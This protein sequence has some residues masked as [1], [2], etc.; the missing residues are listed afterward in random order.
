VPRDRH[1]ASVHCLKC[2]ERSAGILGGTSGILWIWL[3]GGRDLEVPQTPR[4]VRNWGWGN[5]MPPNPYRMDS[6]H[7]IAILSIQVS[8]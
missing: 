3:R 8:G 4:K 6:D 5:Y 1:A 2:Y 7:V